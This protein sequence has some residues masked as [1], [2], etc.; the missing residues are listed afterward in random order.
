MSS[1]GDFL[2]PMPKRRRPQ[3]SAG[4]EVFNVPRPAAF[5]VAA[6]V[7]GQVPPIG[8]VAENVRQFLSDQYDVYPPEIMTKQSEPRTITI[9]V[10]QTNGV[11]MEV[12]LK[13]LTPAQPVQAQPGGIDPFMGNPDLQEG[14]G[15][16]QVGQSGAV[17]QAAPPAQ[18]TIP[19]V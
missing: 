5:R 9:K 18:Q 6:M 14:A 1:T 13:D 3:R 19:G 10:A 8:A 17:P 7:A 2:V 11:N 12:T 4:L 16:A 15:V